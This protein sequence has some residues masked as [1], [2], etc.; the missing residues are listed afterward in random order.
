M[1]SHPAHP[2]A[3]H[4]TPGGRAE[5]AASDRLFL[6]VFPEAKAQL[7]IVDVANAY[8]RAQ[9]MRATPQ[10]S[11]RL[12]VTVHHLGDYAELLPE[13]VEAALAAMAQI[14]SPRWTMVLDRLTGF[15]GQPRHYPIVLNCASRGAHVLWRESRSLL[16]AAGFSRW[17][18]RSYSPHMT[19]FHADR[20]PPAPIP[21]QPILWPVREV[22]LVHSL[23]G[24]GTY[25]VL[26]TRQLMD[27]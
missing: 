8:L 4:P 26:G 7:T 11:S 3:V 13:T 24:K 2:G 21:I 18:E 25:R 23:M 12:H 19:L 14:Q 16:E 5:P 15:P 9:A 6:G 20:L 27:A 10:H 22:V 17:L 1:A